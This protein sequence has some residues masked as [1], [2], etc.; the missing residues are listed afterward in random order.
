MRKFK[1]IVPKQNNVKRSFFYPA[2][3]CELFNF[4][5]TINLMQILKTRGIST[6]AETKGF[7]LEQL[8]LEEMLSIYK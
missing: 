5:K 3:G 7:E 4:E 6:I 1:V 8:T 2:R